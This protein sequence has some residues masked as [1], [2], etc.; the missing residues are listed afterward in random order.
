MAYPQLYKV[1]QSFPRPQV[2]D[3]SGTVA[4]EIA[5][6]LGSASLAGKKV[7]ITVGSRGIQN[8]TTM[9]KVVVDY[10]KGLGASPHLLAAMGSHGGG[11]A[12]G[13]KEVL[14][15]LG[16]TEAALGAP[17]LT[18]DTCREIAR[19]P[20]GLP[21]YVSETTLTMDHILV[22]NRV[23]AHTSLKGPIESGLTKMMVVGLGGPTGAMQ[24][25]GFGLLELPK[26]IEEIGRT[27]LANLPII[28]GIAI[29]ENAEEETAQITGVPREGLVEREMEI[30]AYSKSLM[31]ALP[32]P[33]LDLLVV[34]RV[35][36]NFS[37]TGMDTNIIG[38]ARVHGIP[39]PTTPDI[40]RIAVLDLS[41]ES[42]GNATGLGLADFTTKRV[43]DKLDRKA[44]YLNCLTTTFVVRAAIPMYFD[45]EKELVEA[46]F[47][48]LSTIPPEKLRIVMVPN[49]L[50][51]GECLVS[52]ALL[53]E[54]KK[55][56][57]V[58]VVSGPVAITFDAQGDLTA[59]SH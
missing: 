54:I 20:S 24:F 5:K 57:N 42:H 11:T 3:V 18:C 23:K 51:L 30:L 28:G 2:T 7:G 52:E 9:L 44:T 48:S 56:E 36:K 19:T 53:P 27:L 45:T 46:A 38:R 29:V 59:R 32:V 34:E 55:L 4:A 47:F 43:V 39:E 33:D 40:K 31:P 16:I 49:T 35:G 25:H 26:N 50:F 21:C 12:A 6:V 15:S 58:E 8:I 22:V 13:Q 14:D 1:R 17:V 10:V 37:G 41:E